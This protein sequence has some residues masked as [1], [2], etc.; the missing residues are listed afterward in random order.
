MARQK[1]I[2]SLKE[3]VKD[4]EIIR[5]GEVRNEPNYP[6]SDGEYGIT[7]SYRD[8]SLVKKRIAYRTGT[9][10]DGVDKDKII[11]Y[12]VWED[13]PCYVSTIEGIFDAYA[14]I[15]NLTEFKAKKMKGEICELVAIAQR[16]HDIINTALKGFDIT[17]NKEQTEV[18]KLVDTKIGLT[19]E[20]N[21]LKAELTKYQ[22][23]NKEID[24]MY[25]TIKE[26]TSIIVNRDKAKKHRVKLEED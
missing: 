16:T 26:K 1:G 7:G 14:K 24:E 10:E 25:T 9:E 4:S 17:L 8:Y 21:R 20:I 6:L 15:L 3:T 13:F 23:I 12:V 2:K 22:K 11:E 18:C 5:N 19:E